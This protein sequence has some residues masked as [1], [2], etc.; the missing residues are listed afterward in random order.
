MTNGELASIALTG[1]LVI[2]TGIYAWRTFAISN[3]AK[4]QAEEMRA[5]RYDTVR[6]VID[7]K[8]DTAK[9][10]INRRTLE[11]HAALSKETSHGLSCTLHNIGLGP[12]IDLYSFIQTPSGR[13]RYDFGT[14]EKGGKTERMVLSMKQK[15][16]PSG[17]LL[18]AYYR[19][20][21]GRGCVS[22][23]NV[24]ID[25]KKGWVLGHLHTPPPFDWSEE[26]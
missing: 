18:I 5:Q 1:V 8:R 24:F 16:I 10:D 4:K 20:I 26:E 23:R 14:L 9:T 21:Y 6:P 15:G 17:L 12:A 19:D 11:T 13:Q 2:I 25:K 7:I 3:A 22:S